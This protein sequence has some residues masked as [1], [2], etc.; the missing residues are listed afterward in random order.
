MFI[1][2]VVERVDRLGK[3]G[4]LVAVFTQL[5]STNSSKSSTSFWLSST[6]RLAISDG[7]SGVMHQAGPPNCHVPWSL[8]LPR[9][10]WSR[11][12]F[13]QCTVH[14]TLSSVGMR[15]RAEL[16]SPSRWRFAACPASAPDNR[17]AIG[18]SA[19]LSSVLL[20]AENWIVTVDV[21]NCTGSPGFVGTEW[22]ERSVRPTGCLH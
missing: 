8:C 21:E 13:L 22:F 16:A 14:S 6:S 19:Q 7:A 5:C 10:S 1:G 17:D 9:S 15:W 2:I 4:H 12:T 11:S 18:C 20:S 3:R